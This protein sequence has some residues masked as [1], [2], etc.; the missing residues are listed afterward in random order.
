MKKISQ[1]KTFL[2]VFLLA[3]VAI[4][5]FYYSTKNQH[6][7]SIPVELQNLKNLELRSWPDAIMPIRCK[8]DLANKEAQ[9][10]CEEKQN[11]IKNERN[12]IDWEDV[13]WVWEEYANSYNC[14]FLRQEEREKC[15]DYK[16]Q[17][18]WQF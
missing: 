13:I 3:I 12:S 1:F 11:K 9:K 6:R 16:I 8:T 7:E 4:I 18:S 15:V 5:W 10:Y 17:K 14:D 2:I